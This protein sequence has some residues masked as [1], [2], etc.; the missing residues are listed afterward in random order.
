MLAQFT[1]GLRLRG[2]TDRVVVDA[3]DALIAALKVKADQPQAVITYVRRLNRR[4]DARHPAHTLAK[5]GVFYLQTPNLAS[6]HG[7]LALLFGYMPEPMEV[8]N[9]KNYFG[10]LWFMRDDT[11]IHH[12]RIFTYRALREMCSYYGFE[13]MKAVGI[14]HRIPFVFRPLPGIAAQ[15]CL[16]LEK[17]IKG[18]QTL[19]QVQGDS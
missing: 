8:S 9:V 6:W 12:V 18:E 10:K 3:E 2:K 1:V 5:D 17:R 14:D 16:K 4:G 13:V 19:K 11:P 15:V 7:R